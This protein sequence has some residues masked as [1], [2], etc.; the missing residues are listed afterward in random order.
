MAEI[1]G[2]NRAGMGT[3][4][5][6]GAHLVESE[7]TPLGGRGAEALVVMVGMVKQG[8]CLGFMSSVYL[9]CS[10]RDPFYMGA[11][12]NAGY[13]VITLETTSTSRDLVIK[14]T[15]ATLKQLLLKLAE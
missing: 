1:T 6:V 10:C 5:G 4:V 9:G 7:V 12:I 13:V 3:L 14:S 15:P 2:T 11:F 8:Q